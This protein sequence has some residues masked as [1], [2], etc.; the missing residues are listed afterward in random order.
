VAKWL[1][2]PVTAITTAFRVAV[3][4]VPA[5]VFAVTHRL[6]RALARSQSP[7]FSEMPHQALRRSYR[8]V[9][10]AQPGSEGTGPAQ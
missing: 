4:V 2:V 10:P 3:F 8:P 7:R 1:K 6:L 9:P 5:V